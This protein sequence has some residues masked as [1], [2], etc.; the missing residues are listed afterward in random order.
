ME[1]RSKLIRENLEYQTWYRK[2]LDNPL[3]ANR[4]LLP[5][6]GHFDHIAAFLCTELLRNGASTEPKRA[7]SR[8]EPVIELAIQ[9]LRIADR[10]ILGLCGEL[11]LLEALARSAPDEKVAEVLDAWKGYRET[12]R[13]LQVGDVGIEVKTTTRTTSSHPVQGVHQ[14]ELG[15]GVDGVPESTL[16]LVSIGIQW[17]EADAETS[18]LTSLPQLVDAIVERTRQAMKASGDL[19][20]AQLLRR[21]AEYGSSADIGYDHETMAGSA[22]FQRRFRRSFVRCYDMTDPAIQVLTGDDVRA[23]PHVDTESVRFRINLP[24][25][26]RGDI[27]PTV[28]LNES[29]ARIV[30]LASGR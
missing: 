4:L 15:H 25:Q 7:F 14:V 2:G 13:D 26:V 30:D 9:R 8:T 6:A 10:A 19:V 17:A 16:L 20:V 1:P 27:N 23:R 28:G 5:A 3:A 24:D 18:N 29:A 22:A 21:I 11:L 12:A